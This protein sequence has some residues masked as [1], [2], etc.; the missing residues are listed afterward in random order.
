LHII[1]TSTLKAFYLREKPA[2][3]PIKTWVSIAKVARWLTPMDV[4]GSFPTADIRP[5]G[6]VVFDVGG[7][8][9]RIVAKVEYRIGKVFIRFV[10]THAQYNRI[11]VDTV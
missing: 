8:K 4:K 1:A 2:E 3:Q 9:F 10:G 11:N 7:N 6:R 5:S